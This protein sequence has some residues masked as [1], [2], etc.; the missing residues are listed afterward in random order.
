[1]RYLWT[2]LLFALII[3]ACG[4]DDTPCPD[5]DHPQWTFDDTPYQLPAVPRHIG[6]IEALI[7]ADNPLTVTK[8]ALGKKLF[9]D[10][11]L[12]RDYT[13][14]CASCHHPDKAFSDPRPISLG[15]EDRPGTRNAPGLMNLMFGKSFF[16]DGGKKTLEDQA[17]IPIM[18]N[19]E[20]DNTVE[21]V[22]RRIN[23][24]TVYQRM[25]WEAFGREPD[26]DGLAKA[27]SSF[28]R[29]LITFNTRFDEYITRRNPNLLTPSET[30]GLQLF[31][32]ETADCFHCHVSPQVFTDESF[33]DNGLAFLNNDIGREAITGNPD[34]RL[35][36][37]VSTLR[38]L[39]FTAPYMHDGRFNTLE[40]VIDHY[41]SGGVNRSTQSPFVPPE[42]GANLLSEQEKLD[43]KN[44]LLTLT[45]SSFN[46]NPEFMP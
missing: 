18:A 5:C 45:D 21:E 17:L 11:L 36:F 1:M 35:K 40:E 32:S 43:L 33:R 37:K 3:G 14:S 41:I 8:V 6:N 38:N 7:P 30:R 13:V 26:A 12:S 22:I 4:Q 28:E 27:L 46:N 15:I 10:P 34:D 44:F 24:D 31:N 2:I 20:M 9:Y 42:A 16:W 23:T 29:I 25:F 19:F 39:V